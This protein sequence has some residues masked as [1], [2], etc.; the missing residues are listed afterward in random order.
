MKTS[1]AANDTAAPT[2]FELV[3]RAFLD[4][5]A[6][7]RADRWAVEGWASHLRGMAHPRHVANSWAKHE[8]EFGE[9]RA[10]A[11][12]LTVARMF[13]LGM[14]VDIATSLLDERIAARARKAAA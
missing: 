5:L 14:A 9:A 11:L 10:Y 6:N 3:T 13:D 12:A 1:T 4:V 2:H 8:G 7:A